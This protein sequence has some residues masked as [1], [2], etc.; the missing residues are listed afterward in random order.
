MMA[1][2]V[3]QAV[4]ACAGP[5]LARAM[6][7]DLY[8][9]DQAARMLSTLITIMGAAPLV[10]P[11]LGGQ[12]LQIWSWHAIFWLLAVVGTVS[13]LSMALLPETLPR[14]GRLT[15][16]MHRVWKD[17]FN[18]ARDRRLVRYAASGG[19]FYAGA[20]AFI[21]GTPSVYIDHFGVSPQAYGLL[22]GVNI[23][24]IMLANLLN[25]R[26]VTRI[27]SERMF[28]LGTLVAALSGATMAMNAWSGWGGLAGI[29]VPVFFYMAMNGLIVANSVAGALASF[30]RSA[31]AASSLVGAIHYGSGIISAGLVGWL[32]DGTPWTMGWIIGLS[33]LGCLFMAFVPTG[34]PQITLQS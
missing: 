29:A 23:V 2:R 9:R 24:G 15:E 19:F 26:F 30:P 11:L 18:L 33:G 6:V 16:P 13:L 8:A 25:A 34:H 10:G 20:Y 1:W 32:S 3:L 14:E 7:R 21:A 17:Y 28:V 31:G 27:G 12:I 5:V 22:F 4:G